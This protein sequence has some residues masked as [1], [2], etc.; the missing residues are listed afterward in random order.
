[1]CKRAKVRQTRK[2]MCKR[3]KVKGRAILGVELSSFR[4]GESLWLPQD[5]N[6]RSSKRG[7]EKERP[8]RV[9][10]N[11]VIQSADWRW[12][13]VGQDRMKGEIRR[14]V[15]NSKVWEKCLIRDMLK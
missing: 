10:E 3:A 4:E 15:I 9:W 2:K 7:A 12:N 14:P 13:S 8:K 1:M 6:D 11:K 5:Y